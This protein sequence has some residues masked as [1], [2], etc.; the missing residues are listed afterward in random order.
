M[1][2]V[3]E[4]IL[5]PFMTLSRIIYI[6]IL[7]IISSIVL[8]SGCMMSEMM[9]HSPSHEQTRDHDRSDKGK[10]VKEIIA[11]DYRV[12]AEFPTEIPHQE[13]SVFL[14]AYSL[15]DSTLLPVEGVVTVRDVG[16]NDTVIAR[17]MFVI[18][19]NQEYGYK[20]TVHQPSEYRIVFE[21]ESINDNTLLKSII[22]DA[23]VKSL[24]MNSHATE[25]GGFKLSTPI[26][27]G[28]MVMASMMVIMIMTKSF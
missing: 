7:I 1:M 26:I 20:F 14:W 27:I 6:L 15:N 5:K 22:I 11:D 23:L 8:F 17:Q 3:V 9:M 25:S 21:I 24:P 2:I 13:S 12:V 28:S 18:S 19:K 10:L 16:N 4:K